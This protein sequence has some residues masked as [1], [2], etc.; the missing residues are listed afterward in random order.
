M[1]NFEEK[2]PIVYTENN[3]KPDGEGSISYISFE[4]LKKNLEKDLSNPMAKRMEVI[5]YYR[6]TFI[7][8]ALLIKRVRKIHTNKKHEKP[9]F[10]ISALLP[11]AEV[12]DLDNTKKAVDELIQFENYLNEIEPALKERTEPQQKP[13]KENLHTHI[14]KDNAFYIWRSMFDSFDV[15]ESS[16]TDV[17]FMYEIMKKEGLISDTIGEKNLRDW[18]SQTYSLV[19]NKTKYTDPKQSSNKKR[20]AVYSA[21]KEQIQQ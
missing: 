8:N 20:M 1:D 12:L 5:Q 3:G 10:V 19:M 21:A 11:I 15:E 2:K 14:F 16:L 7:E 9:D 6:K 17:R 18:I 13:K 4:T